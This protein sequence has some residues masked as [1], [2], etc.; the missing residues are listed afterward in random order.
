[1]T[2]V[3]F[4]M[5][6]LVAGQLAA[7]LRQEATAARQRERETLALFEV[8]RLVP[9]FHPRATTPAQSYSSTS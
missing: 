2:P 9:G 3:V 8:A 6:A 7:M 1:V 5:T 4:V